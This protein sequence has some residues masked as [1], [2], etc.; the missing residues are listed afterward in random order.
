MKFNPF[1]IPCAYCG[2]APRPSKD[3]IWCRYC[4][5]LIEPQ[6]WID[7]GIHVLYGRLVLEHDL[8]FGMDDGKV[9]PIP[10][11]RVAA[12]PKWRKGFD[13]LEEALLDVWGGITDE[14]SGS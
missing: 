8:L 11:K 13:T 6:E 10:T 2:R 12:Y 3:Q 14:E 1:D 4:E 7:G 9:L 5:T